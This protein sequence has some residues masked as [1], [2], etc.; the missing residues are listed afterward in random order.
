MFVLGEEK[1]VI[2]A[3]KMGTFSVRNTNIYKI[4]KF[5]T[6]IFSVFYNISP[7]NFAILL[8]QSSCDERLG[9]I[10]N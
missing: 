10:Q 5:H 6:A 7:P 8:S 3:A 1:V 9:Q 4:C 2:S